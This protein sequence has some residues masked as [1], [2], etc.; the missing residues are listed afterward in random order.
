MKVLPC[1]DAALLL[2]LGSLA[3][4]LGLA[5]ALRA[6]PPTGVQEVVP[7]TRTVLLRCA[8]GTDL[9][10]VA[11]A[12]RQVTPRPGAHPGAEAVEVPVRY[13]GPDLADVARLTGRSEQEV[14]E[15]HGAARWTVAFCGFAPGFGYLVAGPDWPVVARR[16]NP[17]TRVPAGAVALAGEFAGVYPRASPGGWQL[18]GSTDLTVFDLARDPPALLR[19]GVR[20]RFVAVG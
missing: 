10:A 19:P 4:V 2:E 3:D 5:A 6:E 15:E 9:R 7:A 16:D 11:A 13:D 1:G 18:I 17:R 12:A 8:P 20:V 14:V